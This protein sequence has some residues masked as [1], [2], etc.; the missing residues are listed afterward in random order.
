[1][2]LLLE[3]ERVKARSHAYK[4]LGPLLSE[5]STGKQVS[6]LEISSMPSLYYWNF[7]AMKT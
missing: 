3:I 6:F 4:H 7:F 2:E 5:F 1:M